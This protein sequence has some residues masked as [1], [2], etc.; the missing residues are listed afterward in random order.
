MPKDAL[1]SYSKIAQM[2][3]PMVIPSSPESQTQRPTRRR[4]ALGADG[5]LNLDLDL[6][7]R[8]KSVEP[9]LERRADGAL[10]ANGKVLVEA[11]PSVAKVRAAIGKRQLR[12]MT[13]GLTAR[14]AL[15][16]ALKENPRYAK[17]YSR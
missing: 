4:L 16:E 3:V 2:I 15:R 9:Y 5:D 6:V 14:D 13:Q 12:L 1:G 11:D 17:L 8:L 7:P 10:L